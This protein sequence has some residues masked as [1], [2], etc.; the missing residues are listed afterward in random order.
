MLGF[1]N[2]YST[3]PDCRILVSFYVSEF[4]VHYRRQA[5]HQTADSQHE[6]NCVSIPEFEPKPQ[7]APKSCRQTRYPPSLPPKIQRKFQLG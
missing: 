6:T 5:F 3:I 1:H 4:Y 7:R 2:V